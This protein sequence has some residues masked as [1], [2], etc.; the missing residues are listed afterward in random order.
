MYIQTIQYTCTGFNAGKIHFEDKEEAPVIIDL[1]NRTAS[2]VYFSTPEIRNVRYNRA[3]AC[4]FLV[5]LV[6]HFA[7][8]VGTHAI[9]TK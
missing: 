3:W 4:F 8:Y 6:T 2:S 7:A 1:T 9:E 5:W